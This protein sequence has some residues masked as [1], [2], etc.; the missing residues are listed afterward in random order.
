MKT[1]SDPSKEMVSL[2]SAAFRLRRGTE[3]GGLEQ[4]LDE[5]LGQVFGGDL[6]G[7]IIGGLLGC[8]EFSCNMYAPR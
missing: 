5:A 8:T 2:N 3:E 7:G 4:L 1:K 6:L